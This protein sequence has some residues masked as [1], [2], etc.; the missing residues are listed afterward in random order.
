MV[1]SF[2]GWGI[3]TRECSGLC[4][5]TRAHTAILRI[6]IRDSFVSNSLRALLEWRLLD[7][8]H[9]PV[10]FLF[11]SCFVPLPFCLFLR[12]SLSFDS[13]SLSLILS[14][15][16]FCSVAPRA[17]PALRIPPS[18]LPIYA[19]QP[20]HPLQLF[21]QYIIIF[22]EPN[23]YSTSEMTVLKPSPRSDDLSSSSFFPPSSPH[24]ASLLTSRIFDIISMNFIR[25]SPTQEYIL[26]FSFLL[27]YLTLG[28]CAQRQPS[29]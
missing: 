1:G 14:L 26:L 5:R 2:V 17:S 6:F 18:S 13:N 22:S 3:L 16:L 10:L 29:L 11:L 9:P 12:A 23:S 25:F 20:P 27:I 24:S 7:K 19:L 8:T 15:R 21:L 28:F 4:P